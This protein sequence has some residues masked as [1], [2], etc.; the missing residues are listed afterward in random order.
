[1]NEEKNGRSVDYQEEY[2]KEHLRCADLAG[3]V[4]DLEAKCED[5]DFKLKRIKNNPIWKASAPARK[6]MHF[7]IRQYG[8]VKN[9][10]N[11]RGILAK[12]RYK[13]REKEAMKRTAPIRNT[14]ML[15]RL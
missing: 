2:E 11:L 9:C 13:Q 5:L 1:M 4:A 8:R 14:H 12:I 3:R 10:G 15:P 6:A 7:C